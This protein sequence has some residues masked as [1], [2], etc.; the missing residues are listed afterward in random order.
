MHTC[1]DIDQRLRSFW[2]YEE[3]CTTNRYSIEDKQCEQHFINTYRRN[4]NGS[5]TVRLPFKHNNPPS[6]GYSKSNAIVRLHQME[7]KFIRNPKLA[8]DYLAFMAEYE[9]LGHMRKAEEKND[10]YFIPHHA[11]IKESSSTTKLR[12][13]LDASRKSSLGFSLNDILMVGP[14][15]QDELPSIITRWRKYP[16]A[17]SSDIEKMYRQVQIDEQDVDYQRIVLRASADEPVQ[18]YQLRTVTYGTACSQYLAIRALHQLAL[19]NVE[20]YPIAAEKIKQDFYVD[21][22]LSGSYTI[23]SALLLQ[24]Q[25]IQ[26]CKSGGFNLRKWSSNHEP[27]LQ[28]VP[29]CDRETKS[30]RIIEFDNSI[31]SLGIYWNP[32]TDLFTFQAFRSEQS[33]PLS[34]RNILSD[35]SKQFDPLGWICPLIVRAKIFIQ[36]LWL[37]TLDWDDEV[38]PK[39]QKEWQAIRSS[40]QT[41]FEIS[42]PR[43]IYHNLNHQIELHGF[44]DASIYAYA[45]V[46][47]TRSRQPDGT[48]AVSIISA[49]TR[50]APVKQK[51]IAKLELAGSHLLASL[52]SKVKSDLKIQIY[53]IIAWTDSSIVLQWLKCHPNQLHTYVANRTSEILNNK[54]INQWRH[55]AGTENPSDCASRGLD[56][57][58]LINHPLW[59]TGPKWLSQP[60]E[61][62]PISMPTLSDDIPEIKYISLISSVH[63]NDFVDV[64][65]SF[66]SLKTLT[67]VFAFILRFIF[68][69]QNSNNRSKRYNSTIRVECSSSQNSIYNSTSRISY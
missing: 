1:I 55:I 45:A 23:Q 13:V 69:A 28:S 14:T 33:T 56:S 4:P 8:I 15:I 47:Y 5:F 64:I 21:D 35:I 51:T 19:D 39:E 31:K 43:S 48:Y 42:I 2:E 66:S 10:A 11:V 40:L 25:L 17:F 41:T 54:D 18:E 38:P 67:G 63:S 32:T 62:W 9:S 60:K 44:S 50:V 12:V 58:S 26:I 52:L 68:N 30:I 46:V 20:K 53:E 6:L 22:L 59:W 27:L 16:V 3:V 49:K 61:K 37:L 7:R 65:Q 36:R 29:E 24:K 34:K 57:K